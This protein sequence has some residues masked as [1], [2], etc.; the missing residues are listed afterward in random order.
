VKTVGERSA[1]MQERIA[2]MNGAKK[3][4]NLMPVFG[5]LF[6]LLVSGCAHRLDSSS[7]G[8]SGRLMFSQ[9]EPI[10]L[11]S[12][13][14]DLTP[15]Y[16]AQGPQEDPGQGEFDEFDEFDEFGDDFE[17]ELISI[18]DPLE[19]WNRAMFHFND[20]LIT[21]ILKPVSTGY[22][23]IV[24]QPLRRGVRNFF[25]NLEFPIRFVNCLL[26]AKFQG[27]GTELARF[28][29]NSTVGLAGLL[30]VAKRDLGID[31]REE[32]FGQT[33]GVYGLGPGI[34]IFWPVLGPSSL[35]NTVGLLGDACLDPLY[36]IS[37]TKYT[38]AAK[39][40]DLTNSFSLDLGEEYEGLKRTVDPYVFVRDAYYQTQQKKIKE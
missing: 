20:K 8:L 13:G 29:V 11:A 10:R 38:I 3:W 5:L 6:V 34:Y 30:D 26:Q 40:Y 16:L 19:P 31:E 9:N 4:L 37:E 14:Q 28:A 2:L 27:A 36:Y 23:A 7:S 32:D 21:W 1:I 15:L 39:A 33:L 22:G 18:A 17:A 35:T 24:P 25:E 12:A